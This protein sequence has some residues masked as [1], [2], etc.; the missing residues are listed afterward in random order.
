MNKPRNPIL[1][2]IPTY[3]EAENIFS[4]VRAVLH[5]NPRVDVLVIDDNSPDGSAQ[6]VSQMQAEYP[7]LHLLEREK[8]EGLGPAYLAGFAWARSQ[9]YT[10]VGQFDADGSHRPLDLPRVIEAATSPHKP[11]LVIGSR[12]IKGGKTKG[13]PWYRRLLSRGGSLYARAVL[14]VPIHDVTA[15][16][17]LY[18]LDFLEH[19]GL[20]NIE[21][22]GY[23]FQ[24]EMTWRAASAGAKILEVPITFVQR[25]FGASKM[26]GS[27][28]TESFVKVLRWGIASRFNRYCHCRNH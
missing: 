18:R 7:A 20:E 24:V 23:G 4:T 10:W 25:Q 5:L 27:I 15:G 3:N 12:W 16:F 9:G 14:Q 28:V 8:K 26:S 2:C 21:S 1:I 6:I 19:M 22:A 11:D 17:R 13:W